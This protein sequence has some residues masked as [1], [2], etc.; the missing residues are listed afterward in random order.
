M[1]RFPLIPSQQIVT[2]D[3]SGMRCSQMRVPPHGPALGILHHTVA[4]LQLPFGS[5]AN[6]SWQGNHSQD[7]ALAGAVVVVVA[8]RCAQGM[9]RTT[10]RVFVV[11]RQG[12][13]LTSRPTLCAA[14]AAE[15]SVR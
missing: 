1:G 15:A 9:D 10:R 4:L 11:A 14:R 6:E 2:V 8:I 12:T 3:A 5:L 13:T 7:D